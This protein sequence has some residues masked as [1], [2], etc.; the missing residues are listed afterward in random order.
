M[1][2]G[3]SRSPLISCSKLLNQVV[4]DALDTR[5]LNIPGKK[6]SLNAWEIQENHNL[7]INSATACGCSFLNIGPA[8]LQKGT[9]KPCKVQLQ[10]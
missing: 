2:P 10:T 5:A 1:T 4:P 6:G 7:F 8:D 9:V 3:L